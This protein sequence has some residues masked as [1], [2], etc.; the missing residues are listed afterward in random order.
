MID[1]NQKTIVCGKIVTINP[2]TERGAKK[3]IEIQQEIDAFIKDN[4]DLTIGDISDK[5]AEW[6]KKKADV[7]WTFDK[8][9]DKDFF[10]SEDFEVSKLQQSEDFFLSFA[11]Y[12]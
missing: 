10:T 5:K 11:R 7:L 3:L 9:V 4:P 2:Y 8:P 1:L 6:Y 12:L